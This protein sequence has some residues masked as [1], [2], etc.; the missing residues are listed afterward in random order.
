MASIAIVTSRCYLL[1]EAVNHITVN[2][3]SDEGMKEESPFDGYL[4]KSKKK[5][6]KKPS[7][8]DQEKP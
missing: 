6:A 8:K 3:R 2:E 4:S 5:K 1:C 7:K